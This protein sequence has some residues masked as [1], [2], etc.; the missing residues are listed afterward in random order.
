M[1]LADI[2]DVPALDK[3]LIMSDNVELRSTSG[4]LPTNQFRK[5]ERDFKFTLTDVNS[6][7]SLASSYV[8]RSFQVMQED[9]TKTGYEVREWD[10]TNEQNHDSFVAICDDISR[11]FRRIRVTANRLPIMELDEADILSTITNAMDNNVQWRETQGSMQLKDTS[12]QGNDIFQKSRDMAAL[13]RDTAYSTF[14]NMVMQTVNGKHINCL[15]PLAQL[16]PFFRSYDKVFRGVQ[17]EFEF[18]I[19]DDVEIFRRYPLSVDGKD[20]NT[21]VPALNWLDTGV[22]M[23][24]H[25]VNFA[26][27]EEAKLLKQLSTPVKVL[28]PNVD[29]HPHAFTEATSNPRFTLSS[30]GLIQRVVVVFKRTPVEDKSKARYKFRGKNAA[31]DAAA[32]V[33]VDERWVMNQ[34]DFSDP[35][36]LRF[37]NCKVDG[38]SVRN[39]GFKVQSAANI[40]YHHNSGIAG[41]PLHAYP[42][43]FRGNYNYKENYAAMLA[44]TGNYG[45]SMGEGCVTYDKFSKKT[46]MYVFDIH[47]STDLM[48]SQNNSV[49]IEG[50]IE[51]PAGVKERRDYTMYAVV[52][53]LAAVEMNLER[54][55]V[56]SISV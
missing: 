39:G 46:P 7:I 36:G 22:K 1:S 11:I 16:I 53:S 56:D 21:V 2:H 45:A 49:E 41:D 9:A 48:S 50:R 55:T 29:I 37:V 18:K 12:V 4:T 13:S 47:D 43:P 5:V 34:R 44:S 25:R 10:A 27:R 42:S 14:S 23:M 20:E 30:T 38:H 52:Y 15:I 31:G 40:F 33:G 8:D 24:V 35:V 6:Y 19:H 51:L 32:D 54:G 28:Y 17:F 26:G 3:K